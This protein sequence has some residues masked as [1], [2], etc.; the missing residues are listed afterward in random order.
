MGRIPIVL[1]CL[2]W[3]RVQPSP[4]R[5][6]VGKVWWNVVTGVLCCGQ[7]RTH[8]IWSLWDLLPACSHREIISPIPAN[9]VLVSSRYPSQRG[10][11]TDLLAGQSTLIYSCQEC[12]SKISDPTEAVF[13]RS[14]DVFVLDIFRLL[15]IL[16]RQKQ[17]PVQPGLPACCFD[18]FTSSSR[19]GVQCSTRYHRLAAALLQPETSHSIFGMDFSNYFEDKNG[20]ASREDSL[21]WVYY[22]EFNLQTSLC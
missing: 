22:F 1:R 12:I 15:F 11:K 4:A 8:H 21:R 19:S 10:I 7:A 17:L 16:S 14:Q 9:T 5:P 13:P 2:T 18:L 20:L 3:S 6:H